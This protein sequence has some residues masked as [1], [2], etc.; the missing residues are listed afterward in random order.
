MTL[1]SSR[2]LAHGRALTLSV[3]VGGS[4][5]TALT[6]PATTSIVCADSYPSCELAIST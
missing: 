1:P 4:I 3:P 5:V 2:T 6:R